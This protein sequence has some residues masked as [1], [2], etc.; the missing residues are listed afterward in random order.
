MI[1]FSVNDGAV[2]KAWASAQGIPEDSKITFLADTQSEL[3]AALGVRMTH[4]GPASVLGAQTLRCKRFALFVDDGVVK[5]C[6]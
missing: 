3:T 2:M 5:V 6:S 4:P 1:V